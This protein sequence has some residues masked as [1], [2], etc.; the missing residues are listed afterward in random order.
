MKYLFVFLMFGIFSCA[1]TAKPTEYY[2]DFNSTIDLGI[3]PVAEKEVS[4]PFFPDGNSIVVSNFAIQAFGYNYLG[5]KALGKDIDLCCEIYGCKLNIKTWQ[6]LGKKETCVLI[7][8][9]KMFFT[10]YWETEN[11]YEQQHLI[12]NLTATCLEK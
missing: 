8:N 9:D 3:I 11:I 4:L 10:I 2:T 7:I 6:A 1:G 5:I 12:L